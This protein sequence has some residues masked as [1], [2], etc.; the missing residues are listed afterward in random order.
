MARSFVV[1]VD[2]LGVQRL[3]SRL[4]ELDESTLAEISTNVVNEV[5]ERTYALAKGRMTKG[6]T[7][8]E[9]YVQSRMA[10]RPA[11]VSSRPRAVI[12][13]YGNITTLGHY[14][15]RQVTQPVKRPKRA[16]GDPARGIAAGQKSAG[17]SVEV[18][19]GNRKIVREGMGDVFT[20]PKIRDSEGN[21]LIFRRIKGAKT[22]N[23][24]DKLKALYGP[25]VYQLFKYQ[26]DLILNEVEEDV[27]DTLANRAEEA[28]KKALE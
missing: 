1:D 6:L 18:T 22:R 15:P 19:K 28:L 5:A 16:K 25:S 4:S 8:S 10:V 27:A 7:L 21:P 17:I 12:V 11:Q 9:A 13:A 3:V 14:A 20:I 26:V 24:K 23:G 2:A